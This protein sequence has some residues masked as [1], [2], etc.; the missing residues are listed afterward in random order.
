VNRVLLPALLVVALALACGGSGEQS[1]VSVSP[2]PSP[3][4]SPSSTSTATAVPPP[5]MPSSFGEIPATIADYLTQGGGS[6]DCLAALFAAWEMP[7]DGTTQCAAADMDGDGEDEY[8]VRVAQSSEAAT[9]PEGLA[10]TV[11]VFD[12]E[13]GTYVAVF[14]LEELA[15]SGQLV[16]VAEGGVPDPA[17]FGVDD[18]NGDG[19]A[20]AAL[21]SSECGAST[22]NLTLCLV[23]STDGAYAGVIQSSEGGGCVSAPVADDQVRFEDG[24]G[25]GVSDLL[26]RE[27]L[28][29]SVGAGPQ[30]E[31]IRTYRWDGEHYVLDSTEYAPSDVRYFKVRD[32]DD[33]FA[34]GDY[35]T[36]ISLYQ[37][38]AESPSLQDV[39]GFGD[40]AEL[41]AY[42]RFRIG[43]VKAVQ[44]DE[45]GALAAVDAA[46]AADPNALH[47]QMA[48]QF[49]L[50]YSKVKHVSAGCSAA[51]DFIQGHLDAFAALWEY[52]Y[53]N[54]TFQPAALCPS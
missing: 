19:R 13:A 9:S 49:R 52:G 42:A 7:S 2:A 54:P 46:I 50:G 17:I 22:C 47:S 40:P 30:R 34:K 41:K 15:A 6:S 16:T 31:S 10:G 12:D 38:A 4:A 24:D 11:I 3:E 18:Y 36:A 21:T 35:Q 1:T 28:I 33:A 51:R 44:G 14:S 39:D 20:E 27:G 53:A 8:V 29:G 48:A 43:L 25:D 23:A 45:E 26:F 32:A 5:A 37:E